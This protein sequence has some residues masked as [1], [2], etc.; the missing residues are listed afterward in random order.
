MSKE[1]FVKVIENIESRSIGI[2]SI[3]KELTMLYGAE[4]KKEDYA[5]INEV[6]LERGYDFIFDNRATSVTFSSDTYYSLMKNSLKGIE[7]CKA[8]IRYISKLNDIELFMANLYKIKVRYIEELNETSNVTLDEYLY[9][10]RKD[11]EVR[12]KAID[13]I[14][15]IINVDK[16]YLEFV[17]DIECMLYSIKDYKKINT[18]KNAY[19][20][21]KKSYY[22]N[23]NKNF[24]NE[25]YR[26][27]NKYIKGID[28]DIKE[29]CINKY[30]NY[31]PKL[32]YSGYVTLI[33]ALNYL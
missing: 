4:L 3:I 22:K 19:L 26:N 12:N 23:E 27:I 10:N 11:E 17:M 28:K 18:I 25:S 31:D 1:E 14:Q 24:Y 15:S 21:G 33:N 6:L 7:A 29:E 8:F 13:Y 20:I 16:E 9:I 32:N 30:S 5:M 2:K